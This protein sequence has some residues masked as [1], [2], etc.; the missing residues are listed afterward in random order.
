ML[1][2]CGVQQGGGITAVDSDKFAGS[3]PDITINGK[4]QPTLV[5]APGQVERWRLVNAGS[6]HRAF[7]YLWLDGVTM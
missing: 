6:N 1:G 7:S 5:L 4:H 3:T 2:P